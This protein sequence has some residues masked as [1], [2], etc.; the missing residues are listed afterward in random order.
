MVK[1]PEQRDLWPHFGASRRAE[2]CGKGLP[3]GTP[4]SNWGGAGEWPDL[5]LPLTW[6]M[7]VS[8]AEDKPNPTETPVT[9]TTW[10][11]SREEAGGRFPLC[12][13]EP[14]SP[15]HSARSLCTDLPVP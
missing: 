15:Q 14:R 6:E 9:L 2:K 7:S 10:E 5:G 3:W 13:S 11:Q 8:H 1:H 4:P 12:P